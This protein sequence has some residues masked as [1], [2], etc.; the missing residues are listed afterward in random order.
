MADNNFIIEH[1]Q[2]IRTHV[3]RI[4]DR[5][6]TLSV[7]MRATRQNVAGLVTLQDHD[8]VEIAQ[9]K[10]RLERLERRLQEDDQG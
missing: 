9:V 2:S 7:E 5:M 4:S 1:L 10:M 3:S 6:G 8:H